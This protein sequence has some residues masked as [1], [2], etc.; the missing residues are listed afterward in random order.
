MKTIDELLYC[1]EDDIELMG[2]D[3]IIYLMEEDG[4]VV[5]YD[6]LPSEEYQEAVMLSQ[7]QNELLL[8]KQ[9][10]D[11]AS[12]LKIGMI[13]M[14]VVFSEAEKNLAHAGKLIKEAK[15]KGAQICVLPECLDL[16]WGNPDAAQYA[17][18]IP[19]RISNQLGE[20]AKENAI[21]LVA[22]ITEKAGEKIYNTAILISDDGSI[23]LKHR[24]INVLT[25]V[26]DVY[27]IGDRLGVAE[28]KY[29]K[30][31]IDICAD[32]AG[33]SLSIGM[34]L[35]RMG[36]DILLSPCA[37]A[38]RPDRDVKKEPYGEEWHKPY[39]TLSSTFAIPVVG[40]SNVGKVE[41][42]SWAGWKAIGNSIAYGSN[43][44]LLAELSY[45]EQAEVV[46]V[47]EVYLTE[48]TQVGTALAEKIYAL[49]KVAR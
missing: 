19:G 42:G 39:K 11:T 10:S 44:K 21:Y 27:S 20:M 18:P 17:E 23:L 2:E 30:I 32:N 47:I 41:K 34:T 29:G 4:K 33:N 45:G 38:V 16:G 22:G 12:G 8:E 35:G 25:G 5:D 37:W 7:L 14:N 36:A 6:Y 1:I 28:T 26:E 46:E 24:K 31:A 15:D 43:G 48:K 13:Q 9:Q 40:V 3:H 49:S